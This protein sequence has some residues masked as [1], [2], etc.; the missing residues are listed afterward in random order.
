[1]I[2]IYI[3]IM[4]VILGG[5]FNMMFTKTKLY[6]KYAYPIDFKKNFVDGKR[7]FG[8]NKT[9]VGFLSMIVFCALTQIIW[10][11]VCAIPYLNLNNELYYANFNTLTFN[12]L[13]GA[14][15]GFAYMV[16]ELPNSFV[17][18]RIGIKPGKTNSGVVGVIFFVVDQFDSVIGTGIVIYLISNISFG[19]LL[20]YILVGGV[21]HII[22]N[23]CLYALK[24]RKNI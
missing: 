18:R 5:I 11:A 17:K 14:L 6:K 16:C 20:T 23:L 21:T 4:P 13:S 24:I 3:T 12:A 22:V 8:N 1:M 10:G 9:W 7:I 2:D 15:L 19:K